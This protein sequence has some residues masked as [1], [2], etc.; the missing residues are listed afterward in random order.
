MN[1]RVTTKTKTDKRTLTIV[2]NV[3]L[4]NDLMTAEICN[5]NRNVMIA[6]KDYER[7]RRQDTTETIV[8]PMENQVSETPLTVYNKQGVHTGNF[9]SFE[10]S[11]YDI[12]TRFI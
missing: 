6:G 9:F 3:N 10:I 11:L 12:P 5:E 2:Y 1:Y 4:N 8:T 7:N